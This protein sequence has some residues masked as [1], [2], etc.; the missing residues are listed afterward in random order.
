MK[1]ETLNELGLSKEQIDT[2]MA[3]HGKSVNEYKERLTAAESERDEF[4]T[5]LDTQKDD[6]EATFL[7]QQKDFAIQYTMKNSDAHD[8]KIVSDLLDRNTIT[9]ADGE[10]SGLSEQLETLQTEKPFLFKQPEP[11]EPSKQIVAGGNPRGGF[12]AEKDAFSRV[13]DKYQ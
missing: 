8:K 13:T 4:K 7:E 1:R 12:F 6:L 10:L 9:I 11:Q 3:E 2:I 5:Q